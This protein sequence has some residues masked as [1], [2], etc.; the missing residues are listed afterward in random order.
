MR[1]CA[2]RQED[3]GRKKDSSSLRRYARTRG[4]PEAGFAGQPFAAPIVAG[5]L[6]ARVYLLK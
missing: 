1:F 2:R 6:L 4:I 3:Y 5:P